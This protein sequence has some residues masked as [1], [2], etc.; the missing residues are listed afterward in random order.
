MSA[1]FMWMI[2]AAYTLGLLVGIVREYVL[3]RIID[4]I[5][6]KLGDET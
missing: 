4:I 5:R 6:N 1:M 2:G 3:L